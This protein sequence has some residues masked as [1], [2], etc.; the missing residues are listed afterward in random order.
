MIT[1][2]SLTV[3]A[4]FGQSSCTIDSPLIL[5]AS[6]LHNLSGNSESRNLLYSS[7]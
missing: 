5:L 1:S 2:P 7:D 4:N 3:L 6:K